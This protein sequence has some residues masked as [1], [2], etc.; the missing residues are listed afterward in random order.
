MS[1]IA[2][3]QTDPFFNVATKAVSTSEGPVELP[4]LYRNVRNLDA[5]F[6]V[7][8]MRVQAALDEADT[9]NFQPTCKWSGKVLIA[10][11]C[12][13]YLDLRLRWSARV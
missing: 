5:F 2:L 6:L 12:F 3:T 4:I 13:E 10:L 11:A 1:A 7:D 9:P 8:R